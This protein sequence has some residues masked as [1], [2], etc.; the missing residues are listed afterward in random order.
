[1]LSPIEI[2]FANLLRDEYRVDFDVNL[3]TQPAG[4][5]LR[6]R[7][8]AGDYETIQIEAI[9]KSSVRLEIELKPENHCMPFI[10]TLAAAD[11]SRKMQCLESLLLLAEKVDRFI[12]QV[13]GLNLTELAASDWPL[14]WRTIRYEFRVYSLGEHDTRNGLLKECFNWVIEAFRPIFD[15][16]EVVIDC[17]GYEEGDVQKVLVNKYERDGRNRTL[18]L[19]AHGYQCSVCGFDFEKAYGLLGK[20]FI[21]VH[22]I[23]PVSKLGEGYVI[24]PVNDLIPVCPNC[25]AMLHRK[26]PPLLPDELKKILR[27]DS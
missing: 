4:Y 23:V 7:P 18:C 9:L 3:M 21:H 11:I 26:D 25:H 1:M 2:Q 8:I 10:E 20:G 6:A 16:L 5:L 13:N 14:E 24:D 22:H 15:L 12:F 27:K 17:P 19:D